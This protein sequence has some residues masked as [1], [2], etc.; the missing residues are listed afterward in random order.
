VYQK[1]CPTP[2]AWTERRH[3]TFGQLLRDQVQAFEHARSCEIEIDVVLEDHVDH[4]KPECRT[5]TH[6]THTCQALQ[7][8]DEWIGDLILYLLRRATSPVSEDDDLVFREI[9]YRVDWRVYQCPIAPKREAKV[10]HDDEPAIAQAQLDEPVDHGS[11]LLRP[12]SSC[13]LS[14]QKLLSCY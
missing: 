12:P 7:V 9:G 4:R 6:D 5:R 2:V 8:G 13:G 10:K 3:Y 1:I 11:I 14:T